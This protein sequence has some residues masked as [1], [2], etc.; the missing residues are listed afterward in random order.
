MDDKRQYY[1]DILG[2]PAW[3]LRTAETIVVE[4]TAG[5][6]YMTAEEPRPFVVASA[7][8]EP[9]AGKHKPTDDKADG[10]SPPHGLPP[11]SS[12]YA[13]ERQTPTDAI[14]T[15]V[16]SADTTPPDTTPK[17][18][19]ETLRTQVSECTACDLHKTRTQTVF[20]VGSPSADWM[21]I[22]EAP[23][24]DED[25][26]GEPFVGRAG[27]LL[28]AMIEAIGLERKEVYIANILK[29]RPPNN[30]DPEPGEA[31]SCEPFLLRQIA[32]VNPKVIL[33]V[34]RIAAQNLLATTTPIGRMRGRRFTFR[35]TGIPLVV[36]YHP[37]YLLRSPLQKRR[38]WEDLLLTRSICGTS[39]S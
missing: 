13:G 14:P 23:G 27:R 3:R 1:L 33:A 12:E 4:A 21:F 37:A 8:T 28:D 10:T 17:T 6:P 39:S 26:Q 19:W 30:R 29:C 18:D 22:G 31:L 36:T 25:R 32:L 7:R 16:T 15:G 38:G 5:G 35:D 2:T 11:I 34:G 20:G 9:E 24:V